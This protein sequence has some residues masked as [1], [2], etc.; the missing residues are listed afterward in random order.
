[1]TDDLKVGSS[2]ADMLFW[3]FTGIIPNTQCPVAREAMWSDEYEWER[4]RV[5][6]WVD[7]G[8]ES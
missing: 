1:M 4:D 7:L 5:F 3:A 8:G 6:E 2:I